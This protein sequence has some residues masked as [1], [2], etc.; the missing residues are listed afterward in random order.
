MKT[1]VNNKKDPT[2]TSYK[3]FIKLADSMLTKETSKVKNLIIPNAYSNKKKHIEYSKKITID[4]YNAYTLALA[5]KLTSEKVY[6]DKAIEI[7]TTWA[8]SNKNILFV[9][10]TSLV[11]A[12]GGIGLINAALLLED[13]KWNEKEF[14]NWVEDKY[15]PAI[16]I[17]R[18]KTNN[19]GNWGNLA[20]L[21]SYRYL[22]MNDKFQEEV[23]QTKK[24]IKNQIDKNGKMVEEAGRGKYGLWYTYFALAPLTQSILVIY[25]ETKINLFDNHSLE[26]RHIKLALDYLYYYT[27]HPEEWPNYEGD[28]LW[29]PQIKSTGI[30]WPSNLYEAINKFYPSENYVF[31]NNQYMPSVGGYLSE[32]GIPHHI[33]WSYPTFYRPVDLKN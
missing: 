11:L 31:N 19:W 30:N 10:D 27:L 22:N 12:Y 16:Q 28:N 5:W 1:Q 3:N 29:R 2:Y 14:D 21:L 8:S 17:A 26:G 4:S 24:L 20:S 33:A 9:E 6:K 13:E 7:L 32:N 25:N 15:L 18:N 23:I